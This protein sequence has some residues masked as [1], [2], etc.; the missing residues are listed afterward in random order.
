DFDAC[1]ERLAKLKK[2]GWVNWEKAGVTPVLSR[3]EAHF[4][5]LALT[6]N[7]TK[8]GPDQVAARIRAKDI[9]GEI[10]LPKVVERMK[11]NAYLQTAAALRMLFNL[12]SNDD[13]L[14]LLQDDSTMGLSWG[15]AT[16]ALA[17]FTRQVFPY[18]SVRAIDRIRTSL[19]PQ[20]DP[21]RWPLSDFYQR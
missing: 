7:V 13:I 3:H 5:F 18:M 15:L 2:Y 11:I 1:R 4:W 20:L 14:T 12:L 16:E 6:E 17:D 8:Y 9:T 19:R 21:Q 10:D